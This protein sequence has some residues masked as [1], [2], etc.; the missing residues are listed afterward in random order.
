MDSFE[1]SIQEPR[2]LAKYTYCHGDPVNFSDPSGHS[3]F[4][5][6]SFLIVGGIRGMLAGITIGGTMKEASYFIST[7]TDQWSTTGALEA[8][9]K[10][11]ATGAFGATLIGS[12]YFA[13]QGIY[14]GIQVWRNPNASGLQKALASVNILVGMASAYFLK[15][16]VKS[17]WMEWQN[18]YSKVPLST[19]VQT[20]LQDI[21]NAFHEGKDSISDRKDDD[22][23]HRPPEPECSGA[24]RLRRPKCDL[25]YSHGNR[26]EQRDVDEDYH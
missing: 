13:L 3:E 12:A 18:I 15:G 22:W 1:G 26:F 20:D 23:F 24:G 10:G 9:G 2:S 11:A 4:S 7:P 25:S 5:L 8:F 6:A 17:Q 21:R 14:D 16:Q 19:S